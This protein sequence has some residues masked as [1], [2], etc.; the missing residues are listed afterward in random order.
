MRQLNASG[1]TA[2]SQGYVQN[3]FATLTDTLDD[4][5]NNV[6]LVM[7]KMAA[8]TTQSQKMACTVAK[9]SESVAAAIN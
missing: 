9:T 1:I 7:K 6:Q 8:L 4:D 2:G 3:T 5:N